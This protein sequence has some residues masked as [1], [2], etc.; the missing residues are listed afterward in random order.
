MSKTIKTNPGQ[1]RNGGKNK[2]SDGATDTAVKASNITA[3]CQSTCQSHRN[4][5]S[6]TRCLKAFFFPKGRALPVCTLSSF[7]LTY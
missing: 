7:D 5:S 3:K 2:T 1:L 4:A 6:G